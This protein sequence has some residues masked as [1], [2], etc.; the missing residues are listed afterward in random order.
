MST[1][2][3]IAYG[4]TFHF[5]HEVLDDSYV[6][7]E[8]EQV[9]FEASYNR[10]M[11]PIPVHIWEVIRKYPGVD[12]SW[13]DKSDTEILD[14]VSQCVDDRIHNYEAAEPD[15]KGLVSLFGGLVFGKADEPRDAQ[16]EQG[17][18]HYQ[19]MRQHQQQV[20]A[21]IADLQQAQRNPAQF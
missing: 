5:Y 20:K 17:V 8:L 7:L 10:V 3:T 9:E 19:R 11:V 16:I 18:A 21:A 14:H 13:A 1:K 2:A 4:D 12:L 15:K 6:Y